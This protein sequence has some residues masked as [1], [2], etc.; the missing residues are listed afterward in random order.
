[1]RPWAILSKF[2]LHS[3]QFLS[4]LAGCKQSR[5]CVTACRRS[6]CSHEF[7]RVWNQITTQ[8]SKHVLC[9]ACS[10]RGEADSNTEV[11]PCSNDHVTNIFSWPQFHVDVAVQVSYTVIHIILCVSLSLYLISIPMSL[12]ICV[13]SSGMYTHTCIHGSSPVIPLPQPVFPCCQAP[14]PHEALN[15]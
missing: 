4:E 5:L 6:R 7:P 9:T 11:W 8:A 1:M 2:L 15:P 13:Y 14:S 12:C 10:V 3:L